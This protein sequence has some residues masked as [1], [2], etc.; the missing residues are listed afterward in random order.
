MYDIHRG[1]SHNVFVLCSGIRY[2]HYPG[3]TGTVFHVHAR[4]PDQS[5]QRFTR[6]GPPVPGHGWAFALDS[7][8]H[9]TIDGTGARVGF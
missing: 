4:I 5:E 1:F 3:T 7:E 2:T 9:P 8:K 6:L